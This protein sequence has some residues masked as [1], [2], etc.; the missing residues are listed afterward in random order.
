MIS[1][2]HSSFK[3]QRETKSSAAANLVSWLSPVEVSK[4]CPLKMLFKSVRHVSDSPP[5]APYVGYRY[6]AES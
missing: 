5:M 3:V 4:Y 6:P 1:F 2:N